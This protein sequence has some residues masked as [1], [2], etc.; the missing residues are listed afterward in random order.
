MRYPEPIRQRLSPGL[1]RTC[2][3]GF[4]VIGVMGAI[5]GLFFADKM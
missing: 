4:I 1:V 2:G 3:V 5:L